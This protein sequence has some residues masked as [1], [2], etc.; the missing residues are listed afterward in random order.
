MELLHQHPLP[1]LLPKKDM[2]GLMCM[3]FLKVMMMPMTQF[4][5]KPHHI[6]VVRARRTMSAKK[7]MA[8]LMRMMPL[9]VM[10]PMMH[11]H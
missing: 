11:K 2:A 6:D 3:T 1:R 5:Q 10:M 4:S 8:G 7:D 9:E